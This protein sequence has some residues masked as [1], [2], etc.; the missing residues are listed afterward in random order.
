[1]DLSF[2]SQGSL[3]W[4]TEEEA[5]KKRIFVWALSMQQSQGRSFGQGRGRLLLFQPSVVTSV[6][7]WRVGR[8]KE[9]LDRQP[10]RVWTENPLRWP[11]LAH[12]YSAGQANTVSGGGYKVNS[13]CHCAVN[14]HLQFKNVWVR[15]L[16]YSLYRMCAPTEPG[17]Q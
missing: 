10:T 12:S 17:I 4:F 6:L 3:F 2:H 13:I 7:R 15:M 9:L 16:L 8:A 5:L 11:V 1:M 14:T